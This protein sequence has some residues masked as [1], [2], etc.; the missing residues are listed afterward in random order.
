M[1]FNK[2]QIIHLKLK[3]KGIHVSIHHMCDKQLSSS[4][5]FNWCKVII[6]YTGYRVTDIYKKSEPSTETECTQ[7]DK[8]TICV[9]NFSL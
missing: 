5:N 9:I 3:I 2:E 4:D 7:V 6:T 1:N 8:K